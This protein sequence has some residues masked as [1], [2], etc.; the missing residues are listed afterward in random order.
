M[1]CLRPLLILLLLIALVACSA[2]PDPTPPSAPSPTPTL[3]PPTATLAPATLPVSTS[4]PTPTPSPEPAAPAPRDPLFDPQ[5]ISYAHGVTTGD[6]QALLEARGSSL[7]TVRFQIGDRSHSFA[8]TLI[9]LSS[10]YSLNPLLLLTFMDVQSG[11]VSGGQGS[12]EQ[13]A[14][15]MG[16]R[17]GG[18]AR[19]GLYSQLRWAALEMR[20]ALRDYALKGAAAPPPLIF[21][22]DT[23]QTV[24]AE[25][26]FSRYILARVVA[27]TTTP[28]LLGV[29]MESVVNSYARLFGDPREPPSD[30]PPLAEPFLTRPMERN[31]PVTSFFDHDAPLLRP[32][33][34][35]KTFW[36][37]AETDRAFA[38]DGHTGW[39]YG[40]GPPERILAAADGLVIFAGN[41]DDGCATP[42]RAVI[43]DHGNG[44][45]TLY[46]HL[47]SLAVTTGQEVA[48]GDI[49]GV[50]GDS[51][52]A[53]GAHLHLQVQYLGRDVDPY[54]WCGRDADPWAMNPAGQVSIWLWADMPSPCAPHPPDLIIVD[55]NDP[56][57]M[58]AGAWQE[59][60]IGYAGASHFAPVSFA[61]SSAQPYRTANLQAPLVAAWRPTLPHA[62]RYQIMAYIPYAL[63]GLDESRHVR[64]LIRHAEGTSLVEINGERERNWWADLGE[65]E[66]DPETALV[67]VSTLAGDNRLGVWVDAVVFVE[68]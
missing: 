21:A 3:P 6:I 37:R 5:R 48:R 61:G 11:L 54:G 23:R 2:T 27:P 13:L 25:I 14:W 24:N 31:F 19:Q 12:P 40:M 39:D 44:Y 4:T 20:F 8:E 62:G 43:I 38:Y 35:I 1:N 16:Y 59:H 29:R 36:G 28:D 47:D 42:A 46:W 9:N 34:H 10:L 15:A 67:S 53:F 22:D 33:G 49:L 57:F 7:A 52:C 60:P 45:R 51:G 58:M 63:N 56:G 66:L 65:Y 17:G 55:E 41:S 68:R 18:G 30:W 64:Y 32:N 26:S 50:A